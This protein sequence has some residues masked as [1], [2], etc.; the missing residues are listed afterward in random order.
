DWEPWAFAGFEA[1]FVAIE[2]AGHGAVR[3]LVELIAVP[4]GPEPVSAALNTAAVRTLAAVVISRAA[5]FELVADAIHAAEQATDD[6][7][8]RQRLAV[9]LATIEGLVREAGPPAG[10]AAN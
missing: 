3:P 2:R 9:A 5:D 8:A 4:Q 10:A 7:T 6:L 1:C